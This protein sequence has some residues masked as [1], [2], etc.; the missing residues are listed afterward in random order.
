MSDDSGAEY[1]IPCRYCGSAIAVGAKVCPTCKM[2][3]RAWKNLIAIVGQSAGLIAIVGSALIFMV[4]QTRDW[5]AA[6]HIS[7]LDFEIPG[8]M[9]IAN[10]GPRD[11][12]ASYVELNFDNGFSVDLPIDAH[13]VVPSNKVVDATIEGPADRDNPFLAAHDAASDKALLKQ[14]LLDP[15]LWRTTASPCVA[16]DVF[17]SKDPAFTT[18]SR[19]YKSGHKE[20]LNFPVMAYLVTMSAKTPIAKIRIPDTVAVLSAP[21]GSSCTGAN[22]VASG[23]IPSAR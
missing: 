23:A 1:Q 15:N 6:D 2:D 16:L 14:V 3:Q 5:F 13:L 19:D 10:G 4:N 21:K 17:S 9:V 22:A 18:M 8:N 20:L 11:V 12:L 7:V